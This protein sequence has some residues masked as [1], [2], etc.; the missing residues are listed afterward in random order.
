MAVRTYIPTLLTLVG[1]ILEYIER[2]DTKI[3]ANLSGE[4]LEAYILIQPA[5]WAF[6]TV[7]GIPTVLP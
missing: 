5:L 4:T 3:R 7:Y 1:L 2:N 6:R